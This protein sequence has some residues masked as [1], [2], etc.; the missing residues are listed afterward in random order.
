MPLSTVVIHTGCESIA[1][2][3]TKSCGTLCSKLMIRFTNYTLIP[4]LSLPLQIPTPFLQCLRRTTLNDPDAHKRENFKASSKINSW[5]LIVSIHR[6]VQGGLFASLFSQRAGSRGVVSAG[7][8]CPE[9]LQS[10]RRVI[11]LKCR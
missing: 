10:L 11:N 8:T 5:E 4:P 9:Y 3:A 7:R 1:S 6:N 2:D